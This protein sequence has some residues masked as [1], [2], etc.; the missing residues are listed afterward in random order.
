MVRVC[1]VAFLVLAMAS[2]TGWAEEIWQWLAPG[3]AGF[4]GGR[5]GRTHLIIV[6]GQLVSLLG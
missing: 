1:V 5:S 3:A 4:G 2:V 6:L